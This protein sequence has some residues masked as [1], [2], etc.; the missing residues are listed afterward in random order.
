MSRPASLFI[1]LCLCAASPFASANT[2]SGKYESFTLRTLQT[3]QAN[4]EGWF[5]PASNPRGTLIVLH[6]YNNSRDWSLNLQW[7]RDREDWNV[8]M[9]DFRNHGTSQKMGSPCTLGYYEIDDVQATVDWAEQRNLARPFLIYGRSMGGSTGMRFAARDKRIEG[10]IAIS[11]FKNAE[12]ATRQMADYALR[13]VA[14]DKPGQSKVTGGVKS[15]VSRLANGAVENYLDGHNPLPGQTRNMLKDVD[16]PSAVAARE[17]LRIWIMSGENDSFPP[18]DQ[19]AILEAS[20][21]P[22]ALKRLVVTPGTNH[23]STWAFSGDDVKNIP[24]HE[25]F[26]KE[27]LQASLKNPPA[28]APYSAANRAEV[29]PAAATA[30]IGAALLIAIAILVIFLRRS[31]ET[32]TTTS[33]HLPPP[34]QG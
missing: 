5:L 23:R 14:A 19:R 29:T 8:V 11:P 12:L 30:A 32:P 33:A 13:L 21:S 17:D 16:V 2:P 28:R 1:L 34:T 15:F 31:R 27:F 4:I 24:G 22:P 18:D 6:G 7:V 25:K 20:P 10:V 9:I 26:V 3:P